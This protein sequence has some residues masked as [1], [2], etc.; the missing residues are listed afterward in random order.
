MDI[1]VEGIDLGFGIW[2]LVRKML[3]PKQQLKKLKYPPRKRLGQNFLI[4]SSIQKRIVDIAQINEKDVV[5]EIGAGLGGLTSYLAKMAREVI[6]LE[7]DRR[8]CSFLKDNYGDIDN[9]HILQEDALRFDFSQVAQEYQCRIKVVANLPYHISS[10]MIFKLLEVRRFISTMVLMLQKEVAE[11]VVAAPGKKD[12][13]VLSIFTQ[14]YANVSLE[15]ILPPKS[16]Y[17]QPKV[18]SAVVEFK[19]LSQPRIELK[20]ENCFREVVK[21]AF[22]RRRKTIGN[23][24][25]ALPGFSREVIPGIFNEL[26]IDPRRRGETLSLEEWGRLS[27][28]F[29]R[30]QVS[31]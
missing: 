1:G 12:Y 17:P 25:Q 16:F 2:S 6:A 31:S 22:S 19:V 26:K 21:A 7:V 28:Y 3:S 30:E 4:D 20:D 10:Q 29:S 5:V 18:D 27:N 23:A 14:L 11:R 24:L 9:L 15:L 13:G 8:L